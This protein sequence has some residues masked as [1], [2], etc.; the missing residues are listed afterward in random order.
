MARRVSRTR[1]GGTMTEAQFWGFLRS[2]L[3][4]ASR[5]WAPRRLVLQAARRPSQSQNKRLKW[6][7]QCAECCQWYPKKEV[8]VDH[9]VPVGALKSLEDVSGFVERLFCE[10][11]GLEVL[12]NKCHHKKTQG[13]NNGI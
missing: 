3:R 13:K 6:E 9:I 8:E 4:L 12:C 2:N 11:N 1:A 10:T 5:K 7:F